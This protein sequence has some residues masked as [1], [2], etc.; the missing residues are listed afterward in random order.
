MLIDDIQNKK[1]NVAIVLFP[2]ASKA[3][4]SF[5]SDIIKILDSTTNDLFVI[6]GNVDRINNISKKTKIMNLKIGIHYV[7]NIEPRVYSYI[8]WIVKN[9]VIQIETT[10]FLVYISKKIDI[11]VFM[12]YPYYTVPL[13]VSKLLKLKN[14]ELITRSNI[15]TKSAIRSIFY[16]ITDKIIY[17]LLT[18]VS[19]ESELL[20]SKL[21]IDEN[22]VKILP[23]CAR[24]VDTALF[25]V[26][27]PI[28][29]RTN[30]IGYIGRFTKEK[31]FDEFIKSIPL[32]AEKIN[33]VSFLIIGDGDLSEWAIIEA[34]KIKSEYGVKINIIGWS[35][36]EIISN[37][38]NKIKLLVL[39]SPSEGLPTIILEAMASG[40]PI[41]ATTVGGIPDLIKDGKT[42]YLLKNNKPECICKNAVKILNTSNLE[43]VVQNARELI[44]KNYTY[45][46]AVDRFRRL[47]GECI[48]DSS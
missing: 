4:Y 43:E 11:V 44:E 22:K 13:I 18:G 31:G 41:L 40:T 38:L 46:T 25:K 19:P 47:I 36:K 9:I 42:G 28:S 10:L 3:P 33:N 35:S 39:P 29:K 5:L 34:E 45:E 8:L 27:V 26:N 20:I 1:P 24:F 12:A 30:T 7:K 17:R 32:I 14:V 23:S 15:I 37:Y 21:N 2:W 6:T 48:K 16:A